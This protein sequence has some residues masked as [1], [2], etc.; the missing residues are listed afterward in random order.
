MPFRLR[1]TLN[2]P[3]KQPKR[4]VIYGGTIFEVE[5]PFSDRQN[6]VATGQTVVTIP[7]GQSQAIEIDTWCLNKPFQPPSNTPMRPTVLTTTQTY[8]T[9]ESLWDDMAA[10]V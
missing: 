7:P 3:G 8:S 1:L 9:Q 5:D 10:R 6:L 2:N 4:T